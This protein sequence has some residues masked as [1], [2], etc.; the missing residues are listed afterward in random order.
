MTWLEGEK[1]IKKDA[2]VSLADLGLVQLGIQ[3][4]LSQILETGMM[5]MMFT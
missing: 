2:T 3:C 5:M 4:T 1:L